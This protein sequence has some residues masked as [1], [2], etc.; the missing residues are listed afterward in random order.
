MNADFL[1]IPAALIIKEARGYYH[2]KIYYQ[3]HYLIIHNLNFLQLFCK[4]IVFRH[5]DYKLVLERPWT[6]E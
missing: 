3:R 2:T 5:G 4:L 6:D 1:F